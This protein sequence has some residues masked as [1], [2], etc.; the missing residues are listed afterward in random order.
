MY[1]KKCKIDQKILTNGVTT[2]K[3]FQDHRRQIA[4][5]DQVSQSHDWRKIEIRILNIAN[6]EEIQTNSTNPYFI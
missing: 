4:D 1:F 6:S 2:M 5:D 3:E